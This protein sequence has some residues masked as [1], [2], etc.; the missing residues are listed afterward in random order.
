MSTR[1]NSSTSF[2]P[3]PIGSSAQDQDVADEFEEDEL[4]PN[5]TFEEAAEMEEEVNEALA[6]GARESL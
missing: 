2:P 4:P 1:P 6:D 5:V 3:G